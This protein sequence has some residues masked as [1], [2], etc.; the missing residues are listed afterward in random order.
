MAVSTPSLLMTLALA[1][2][3]FSSLSVAHSILHHYVLLGPHSTAQL[4][5]LLPPTSTHCPSIL[6]SSHGL[7]PMSVRAPPSDRYPVLT[8]NV[9]LP[10]GGGES[11]LVH[12]SYRW[13]VPKYNFKTTPRIYT[14]GDSGCR[15]KDT[16]FQA[17]ANTSVWPFASVTNTLATLEAGLVVHLGDYLYRESPCPNNTQGCVGSPTGDTFQT[18]EED[19][20]RPATELLRAM[21]WLFTRGNH[22]DCERFG[23]GYFRFL[24]HGEYNYR[25]ES[26]CLTYTDPYMVNTGKVMFLSLDTASLYISENDVPNLPNSVHNSFIEQVDVYRTQFQTLYNYAKDVPISILVTHRPI[27]GMRNVTSLNHTLIAEDYTLQEAAGSNF[28][29]SLRAILSGHI[30]MMEYISFSPHNRAAISPS[31]SQRP[32]QI[33]VGTAGTLLATPIDAAEMK[34]VDVGGLTPQHAQTATQHGYGIV[35]VVGGAL[36]FSFV[37]MGAGNGRSIFNTIF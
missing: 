24:Y 14:L 30:H 34:K 1:L 9:E 11:V 33:V 13:S 8:C 10:K 7:I 28:P 36:V 26:N 4:R 23:E 12:G 21:P 35:D 18:W 16:T 20:F 32:A 2:L 37:G 17:C 27:Y 25:A 31:I 22:E 15:M 19:F 3:P 6:D 5:A 29:T